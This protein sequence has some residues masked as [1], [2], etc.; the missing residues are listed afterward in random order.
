[1]TEKTDLDRFVTHERYWPVSLIF[2]SALFAALYGFFAFGYSDDPKSCEA[3]SKDDLIGPLP[4]IDAQA[5][6]EAGGGTTAKGNVNI[7]Y[8][9]HLFFAIGFYLSVLQVLIGIFAILLNVASSGFK[10]FLVN[11]YKFTWFLIF[12]NWVWCLLVRFQESGRTCSGDYMA[13]RR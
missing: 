4:I 5:A 12:W 3:S 1:M 7:A 6:D 8:R 2:S 11:L 10:R 13:N 9:F